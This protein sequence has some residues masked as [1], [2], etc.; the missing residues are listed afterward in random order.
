MGN[1]QTIP[2]DEFV[3]DLVGIFDRLARRQEAGVRYRLEYEFSLTASELWTAYDPEQVRR[4]LQESAGALAGVD[5]DT[6][7]EDIDAARSQASSGRPAWGS[8]R[9]CAAKPE[10]SASTPNPPSPVGP[11]EQPAGGVSVK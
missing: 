4:A 9:G 7:L 3:A 10:R 2:F 1:P 11:Q 5:C 8:V 6:L